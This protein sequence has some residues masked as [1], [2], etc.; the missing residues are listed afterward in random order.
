MKKHII[1]QLSLILIVILILSSFVSCKSNDEHG[2]I[3]D[4]EVS[5]LSESET[6]LAKEY[7]AVFE[8]M[9]DPFDGKYTYKR[10]DIPSANL[11][12]DIPSKWTA[13]SLSPRYVR[14]DTPQNDPVLPNKSLYI[15]FKLD[16]FAYS[17]LDEKPSA[18]SFKEFFE[19]DT[20]SF[21]W[22]NV[23]KFTGVIESLKAAPKE[24][25]AELTAIID[26]E[27][28]PEFLKED[29]YASMISYDNCKLSNKSTHTHYDSPRKQVCLTQGFFAW[30]N[31]PATVAILVS[32]EEKETAE[33]IVEY[34]I[35]SSTFCA[36]RVPTAKNYEIDN[37]SV[38]LPEDF[39]QEEDYPNIFHASSKD[40]KA[41]SGMSFA[42]FSLEETEDML[43][44]DYIQEAKVPEL[45]KSLL[46]SKWR[47]ITEVSYPWINDW[48]GEEIPGAIQSYTGSAQLTTDL[49]HDENYDNDHDPA[50][51]PYGYNS[52]A[53]YD[54]FVVENHGQLYMLSFMYQSNQYDIIRNIEKTAIASFSSN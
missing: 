17:D 10:Y 28:T 8:K 33:K 1:R 44:R 38:S 4:V 18:S 15:K 39:E 30:A 29:G 14:F 34:I 16:T 27:Y 42:F 24:D 35:S 37:L 52:I 46:Y 2:E 7:N 31:I 23:E 48:S 32:P 12:V 40:H 22:T 47:G 36:Q 51:S 13:V 6:E 20:L 19:K 45:T 26:A 21:E 5:T 3:N 9:A 50:S 53:L 43:N 11:S 25:G 54:F 49:S 41:T